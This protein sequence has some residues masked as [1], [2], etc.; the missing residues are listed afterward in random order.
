[1]SKSTDQRRTGRHARPPVLRAYSFGIVTAVFFLLS[2]VGQFVFQMMVQRNDSAEHGQPFSWSEY[3]PQFFASTL[4][5]WQS[6]FL[7][8]IWQAAGLALFYFWGSSQ[9]KEGDD[10]LEA[11]VDRLLQHIDVDP[12]EFDYREADSLTTKGAQSR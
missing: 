5:N 3:L 6:E 8:L 2:W 7:Q 10:R 11:K 4:E 1:M 9:S 12:T